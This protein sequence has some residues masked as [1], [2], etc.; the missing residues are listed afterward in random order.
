MTDTFKQD[1]DDII[2]YYDNR[3]EMFYQIESAVKCFEN[4]EEQRMWFH[5]FEYAMMK[6]DTKEMF[7]AFSHETLSMLVGAFGANLIIVV[8]LDE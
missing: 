7:G 8:T 6:E 1:I 2:T 4:N 5:L 3:S